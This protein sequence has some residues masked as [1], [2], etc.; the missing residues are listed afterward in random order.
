MKVFA[1]LLAA[2]AAAASAQSVE[3]FAPYD[4]FREKVIDKSKWVEYER[5]RAIRRGALQLVQRTAG[6][7]ASDSGSTGSSFGESFVDPGAVTAIRA[8]ITVKAIEVPSCA[9][10]AAVGQSRA[11]I[12]GAFF[13]AGTPVPGSLSGDV[14]AQVRIARHSDSTDP[15]GVLRVEGTVTRCTNA[16]CSTGVAIG[17]FELGVVDVGQATTVQMQWD[18]PT[19]SFLF[20]RDGGAS[21]A[22]VYTDADASP[23]GNA[24]KQLQ[25][26]LDLPNCQSGPAAVGFVDAS[27][28]NV[29][30]NQSAAP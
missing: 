23:P 4:N 15:A 27:F 25:T 21:G 1:V 10:N 14:L 8:K 3:P 16:D 6:A 24:F 19:N 22:V 11:R 28:D 13:N 29:S 2:Y 12:I 5:T 18:P 17:N 30:V 9:A 7:T 20:S 26:R